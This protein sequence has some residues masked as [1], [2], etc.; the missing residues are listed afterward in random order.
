MQGACVATPGLKDSTVGLCPEFVVSTSFSLP[1][2]D[3]ILRLPEAL[4]LL[5]VSRSLFYKLIKDG[6]YPAPVKLGARAVGWRASDLQ[7]LIKEG[8]AA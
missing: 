1:H 7:K 8:V 2:Q 5:K 6:L 3:S 4:A